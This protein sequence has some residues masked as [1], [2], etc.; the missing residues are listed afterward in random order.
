[1]QIF[2]ENIKRYN[3]YFFY[4]KGIDN[5]FLL[6][7]NIHCKDTVF[8]EN[9]KLKIKER[10]THWMNNNNF[11]ENT[12]YF[13]IA[14][15]MVGIL[16][17]LIIIRT[18]NTP[19]EPVSCDCTNE[20]LS[21]IKNE[22]SIYKAGS[23]EEAKKISEDIT[24]IKEILKNSTVGESEGSDSAEQS[25]LSKETSKFKIG[26]EVPL[27]SLPTNIKTYTDYRHYNLWYTPHYRMQQAAY[28]DSNGLRR[29]NQDYIVALGAF[30]STDI[31]DRFKITLDNGNKFTI[32]LGDG[33][34]PIDCD[35]NNM[36]APCK[37]Y[38][39][40][41]CANVLE[42]IIDSDVM[43]DE[44]YSYGSIDCIDMFSGSIERMEY[45]GRDHSADWSTYETI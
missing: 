10:M 24:E 29:F 8:T 34:D 9:V 12:K 41:A 15:L 3:F 40:I 30:Y 22:F 19:K 31:G 14:L 35:E 1:M 39:D 17:F 7:Y 38:D 32:I 27:P 20:L 18:S 44:V 2:I 6:C 28:T 23:Q 11:W 13:L 21:V 42:F 26:E 36:Y 5:C 33:K 4:K 16:A 45:L 37:D 43:A 25:N